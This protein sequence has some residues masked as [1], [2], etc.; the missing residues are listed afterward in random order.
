[1][2]YLDNN[3]NIKILRICLGNNY[4]KRTEI[5]CL[6]DH[7]QKLLV[8]IKKSKDSKQCNYKLE[9]EN[10]DLEKKSSEKDEGSCCPRNFNQR[11]LGQ[12]KDV[13]NNFDNLQNKEELLC[14]GGRNQDLHK[15]RK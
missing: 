10:Q 13:K 5:S 1:M 6:N 9:Q 8:Q 4:Y 15:L 11:L 12:I 2:N 3:K 7:N 14:L